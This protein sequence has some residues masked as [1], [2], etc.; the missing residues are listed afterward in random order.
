MAITSA[1]DKIRLAIG[2][3]DVAEP[4]LTDA[5]IAVQ[6]TNWPGNIELAAANCAEAIAAKF[7]RDFDF[8][9][10]GNERFLRSQRVAHYTA[11]A[12]QLRRRAGLFS[13][14]IGGSVS[15]IPASG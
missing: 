7:G 5:E 6:V 8:D 9:V 13:I 1:K 14:P 3:T 10:D 2:D 4:L 15:I 11:L 12:D